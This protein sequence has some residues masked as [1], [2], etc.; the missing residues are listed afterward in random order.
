MSVPELNVALD[1]AVAASSFVPSVEKLL[2]ES[3]VGRELSFR[4]LLLMM[5]IFPELLRE[6]TDSLD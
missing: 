6:V 3:D 2:E 4:L 1:L 5:L